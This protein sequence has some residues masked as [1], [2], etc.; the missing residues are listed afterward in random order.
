MTEPEDRILSALIGGE[1]RAIKYAA[2]DL[3]CE[4]VRVASLAKS[5]VKAGVS[6]QLGYLA[7]ISRDAAKAARVKYPVSLDRLISEISSNSQEYRVL[8]HAMPDF[9]KR[10]LMKGPLNKY[11]I[12]WK[13]YSSLL[14]LEIQDWIQIYVKQDDTGLSHRHY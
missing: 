14:P 12:K 2:L 4:E 13:T 7:E 8:A 11:S 1:P 9:G 3:L 6:S 5:A 10:I